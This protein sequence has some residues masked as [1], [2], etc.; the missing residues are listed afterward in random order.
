MKKNS[1][2][3]AQLNEIKELMHELADSC[4]RLNHMNAVFPLEEAYA[5][6]DE[7]EQILYDNEESL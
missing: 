4:G 5:K 3:H 7:V 1:K 2:I 6:L